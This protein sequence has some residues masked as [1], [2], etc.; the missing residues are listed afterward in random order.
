MITLV[1]LLFSN[2]QISTVNNGYISDIISKT[3]GINQ[4]CNSSPL[5]YTLCGE[6]LNHN[7]AQNQ[8]I[9]RV[10]MP[11]IKN[12]LSQFAD[13]TSAFLKYEKLTLNAFSDTLECIETN[14][15]LKV[16]YDKTTFYMGGFT[17]K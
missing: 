4:G 17:S 16:S 1:M 6:I 12:I 2:I 3:R 14:L 7:I 13:D 9:K 15:G 11:S 5:I 10:P 8:T